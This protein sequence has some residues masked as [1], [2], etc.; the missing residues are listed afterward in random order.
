MALTT[1]APEEFLGTLILALT[2]SASPI[3]PHTI[4]IRRTSKSHEKLLSA[5]AL[6]THAFEGFQQN[7]MQASLSMVKR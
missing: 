7:Q 5:T 1:H 6:N 3:Y 2:L 4:N